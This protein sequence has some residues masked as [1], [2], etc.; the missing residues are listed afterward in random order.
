[1]I[2]HPYMKMSAY[3]KKSSETRLKM[4]RTACNFPHRLKSS[5]AFSEFLSKEELRSFLFVGRMTRIVKGTTATIEMLL[6]SQKI[7]APMNQAINELRNEQTANNDCITA[8]LL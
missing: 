5:C 6:I 8:A 2:K 1:M 7:I 4:L 3:K